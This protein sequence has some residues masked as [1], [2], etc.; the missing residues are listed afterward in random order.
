LVCNNVL[1]YICVAIELLLKHKCD[2]NESQKNYKRITK[3]IRVMKAKKSSP[4]SIRFNIV[5][6]NHAMKKGS[7]ESAQELVDV[8]LRNYVESQSDA[9]TGSKATKTEIAKE[10][11]ATDKEL[12]KGDLLKLMRGNK[13]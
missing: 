12:S 11:V 13:L 6:F 7:F 5:H 8:L 9:K 10:G 2:S 4:K 3:V 1:Y